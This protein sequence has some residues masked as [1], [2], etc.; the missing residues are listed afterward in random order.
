MKKAT[1]KVI[2]KHEMRP[3]YDFSGGVWSKHYQAMRAD[4]A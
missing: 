2:R 4:V 3:E 1:S